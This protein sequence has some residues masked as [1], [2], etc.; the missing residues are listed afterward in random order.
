M[1][2]PYN[3]R[4]AFVPG[5]SAGLLPPCTWE[6]NTWKETWRGD[7][8][9]GTLRIGTFSKYVRSFSDVYQLPDRWHLQTQFSHLSLDLRAFF[10]KIYVPPIWQQG[11]LTYWKKNQWLPNLGSA[12][13]SP[14]DWLPNFVAISW[15]PPPPLWTFALETGGGGSWWFPCNTILLQFAFHCVHWEHVNWV[16]VNRDPVHKARSICVRQL[17]EWA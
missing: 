10:H 11:H 9:R 2:S 12:F 17:A 4:P 5:T 1:Q 8:T 7:R 3:S 15:R 14:L 6:R 13:G 16:C